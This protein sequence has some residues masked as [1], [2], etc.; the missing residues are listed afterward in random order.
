MKWGNGEGGDRKIGKAEKLKGGNGES[1]SGFVL[2]A[3]RFRLRAFSVPR[4]S[5][6]LSATTR[7]RYRIRAGCGATIGRWRGGRRNR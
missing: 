2:S 6:L 3:Y 4:F 5:V 1:Q 7:G